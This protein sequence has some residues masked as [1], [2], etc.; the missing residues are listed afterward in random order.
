MLDADQRLAQLTTLLDLTDAQVEQ[1]RP[2]VEEQTSKQ[3]ALF[4]NSA[5][6]REKM[7]AEMAK[8]RDETDESFAEVLTEQQMSKYREQRQ[9]RMRQGRPPGK[10]N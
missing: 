1:M 4:Q 10:G 8:L 5:A 7:R 2:I 3:Q 9:Q 6:D